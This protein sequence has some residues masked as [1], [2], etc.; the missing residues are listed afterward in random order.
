MICSRERTLDRAAMN[1][2]CAI[3]QLVKSVDAM[4]L[5]TG[6]KVIAAQCIIV[7]TKTG[8]VA[9]ACTMLKSDA[10]DS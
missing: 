2:L 4:L 6:R 3:N 1:A 10:A 7:S 5:S 9:T 8:S